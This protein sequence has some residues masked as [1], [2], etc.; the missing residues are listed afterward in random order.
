MK[1]FVIVYTQGFN[2]HKNTMHL[3]MC[4]PQLTCSFPLVL[5]FALFFVLKCILWNTTWDSQL[6]C[7]LE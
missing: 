1:H 4:T 5:C 2:Q 3:K 6:V 7:I